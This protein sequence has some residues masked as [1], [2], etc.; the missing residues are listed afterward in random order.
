M[1]SGLASIAGMGAA[2]DGS[3]ER[4]S[5]FGPEPDSRLMSD[6]DRSWPIADVTG[7]GKRSALGSKPDVSAQ[8]REEPEP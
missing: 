5:D 4:I 2:S 6:E 7:P 1:G 3:T 8:V